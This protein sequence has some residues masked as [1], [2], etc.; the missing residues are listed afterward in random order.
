MSN[1]EMSV[2]ESA[3]KMKNDHGFCLVPAETIESILENSQTV[4]AGEDGKF[5]CTNCHSFIQDNQKFCGG[6]GRR[7]VWNGHSANC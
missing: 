2:L 1:L 3:L 7:I 4:P 5:Y 6:C